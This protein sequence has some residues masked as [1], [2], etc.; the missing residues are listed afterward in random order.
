MGIVCSRV[1]EMG[2]KLGRSENRRKSQNITVL[3]MKFS[4][5]ENVPTSDDDV[6]KLSPASQRPSGAKVKTSTVYD[7]FLKHFYIK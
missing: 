5:V 2:V 7:F 4:I 6:F 1:G 3:R